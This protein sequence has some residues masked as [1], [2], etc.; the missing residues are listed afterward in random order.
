MIDRLETDDR[1]K[2]DKAMTE[3]GRQIGPGPYSGG[4]G[5]R[6]PTPKSICAM[7]VRRSGLRSELEALSAKIAE[8]LPVLSAIE[9]DELK[10]LLAVEI[11]NIEADTHEEIER[12]ALLA[13]STKAMDVKL[14]RQASR[15]LQK[16]P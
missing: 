11:T 3:D 6:R 4:H 2:Q 10:R 13:P 1:H 12:E 5:T 14:S 9:L 15:L 8:E 16:Q 7:L